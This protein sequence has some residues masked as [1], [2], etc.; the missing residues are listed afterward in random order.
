MVLTNG[1]VLRR[2]VDLGGSE[3]SKKHRVN[4]DELCEQGSE[5]SV[6]SD[7]ASPAPCSAPGT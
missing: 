7:R 6:R 5:G 2:V 3:E 4:H 1:V